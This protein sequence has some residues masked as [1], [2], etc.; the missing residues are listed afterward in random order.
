MK[1][2]VP[3]ETK[4]LWPN[5]FVKARLLLTTMADATV[6]PAG[7]VQRGP[8]G[9]FAYV[10]GADNRVSVRPVKVTL[11]QGETAI[12]GDGLSA[13]ELVVTEGQYQLR[14]GALVAQKSLD[15]KGGSKTSGEAPPK[16][17]SA[18]PV[19]SASA[20][21]PASSGRAANPGASP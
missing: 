11:L 16:A 6:V 12:I 4:L 18:T 1:A 13:G 17:A 19:G 5:Q 8:D 9:T 14:P 20:V 10:V 3:N 7:V 21:P 2:I 15:R